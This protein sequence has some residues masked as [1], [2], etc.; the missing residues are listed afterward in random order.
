MDHNAKHLT[1]CTCL[2]LFSK[3]H[4]YMLKTKGTEV[5]GGN[6]ENNRFKEVF[7]CFVK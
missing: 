7:I 1:T 5:L 2:P 4:K 3:V 6:T